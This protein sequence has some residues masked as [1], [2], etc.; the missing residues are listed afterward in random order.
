MYPY[1]FTC[2]KI[3]KYQITFDSH[4]EM[5]KWKDED[6]YLGDMDRQHTRVEWEDGVSDSWGLLENLSHN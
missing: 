2:E 5:Q 6:R 1:E 3:V 4:E